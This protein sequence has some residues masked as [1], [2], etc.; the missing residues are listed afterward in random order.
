[1]KNSE[2]ILNFLNEFIDEYSSE[3]TVSHGIFNKAIS[4]RS[5]IISYDCPSWLDIE[6]FELAKKIHETDKIAAVKYIRDIAKF[7]VKEPLKIAVNL[8]KEKI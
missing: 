6:D 7:H 1:M 4:I 8:L 2:E 5:N 3:G